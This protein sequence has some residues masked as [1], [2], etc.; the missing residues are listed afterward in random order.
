MEAFLTECCFV[1]GCAELSCSKE[2]LCN[3]EIAELRGTIRK[4]ILL[5][6]TMSRRTWQTEKE[7]LDLPMYELVEGQLRPNGRHLSA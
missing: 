4:M 7:E 1:F 2:E 3:A 5:Q 6:A